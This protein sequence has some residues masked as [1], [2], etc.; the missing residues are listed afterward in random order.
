MILICNNNIKVEVLRGRLMI[1]LGI[2]LLKITKIINSNY[3]LRNTLSFCI[4][5]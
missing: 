4:I 3:A 1:L 5:K 2:T